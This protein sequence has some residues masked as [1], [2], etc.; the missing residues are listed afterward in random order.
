[1]NKPVIVLRS[2]ETIGRIED[3]LSNTPHLHS[4]FPVVEQFDLIEVSEIRAG[5]RQSE[6]IIMIA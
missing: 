6:W 1:M 4:G 5:P 3:V 2:Q